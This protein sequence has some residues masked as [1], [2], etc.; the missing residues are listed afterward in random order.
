MGSLCAV[1]AALGCCGCSGGRIPEE[2]V[3]SLPELTAENWSYSDG[4]DDNGFWRDV[5]AASLVTLPPYMG[6]EIPSDEIAVSDEEVQAQ[7]DALLSEYT[8]PEK[9]TDRA[10]AVG[11]QVCIDY[12][13]SVDGVAFEGGSTGGRGAVVTIGVTK[14]IDDFLDQLVGHMPGETVRVEVTFPDDYGK[15][16]LNGRDAVFVTAIN[17]ILG[18]AKTPEL[19]DAFVAEKLAERYGWTTVDAL[20]AGV[21]ENLETSAFNSWV[22]HY[23]TSGSRFEQVPEAMLDYQRMSILRYCESTA[24]YLNVDLKTFLNYYAGVSTARELFE[25]RAE[26]IED[27]AKLCLAV[28]AIAERESLAAGEEDIAF[29][30]EDHMDGADYRDYADFYGMPYMK[31]SVCS[32]LVLRLIRN[33][34]VIV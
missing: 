6:L 16:E 2:D 22:S 13:G 12:V 25:A 20:R 15:E 18:E 33:N 5:D 11:D 28:Q 24:E 21:R 23:L 31:W 32:D 1:A 19:N 26:A 3:A 30:F 34:A 8:A 29:Y 9:I 4:L 10:I 14:Y 7:I 17:Y 27:S